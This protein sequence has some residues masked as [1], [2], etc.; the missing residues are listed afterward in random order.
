[1]PKKEEEKNVIVLVFQYK[2]DAIRPE[3]SS[4]PRFKI[5]GGGTLSVM[6][7]EVRR[8]GILVS[9]FGCLMYYILYLLSYFFCLLSYVVCSMSYVSYIMS[10]VLCF[11]S[12]IPCLMS[13][14]LR[15]MS[16]G[17]CLMAYVL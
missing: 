14:V 3:L 13:Y 10:Y 17:L 16:Y 4:P 6:K 2:D 7:S 15:L 9:N 11:M 1:M 5:Q 12:H 8:T